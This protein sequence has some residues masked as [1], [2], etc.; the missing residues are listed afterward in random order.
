MKCLDIAEISQL[1]LLFV[2]FGA[3][4][5]LIKDEAYEKSCVHSKKLL[6]KRMKA[7]ASS[8][9]SK[10]AFC[11]AIIIQHMQ[12]FQKIKKMHLHFQII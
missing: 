11:T 12:I 9:V 5:P 10:T 3:F 8:Q 4:L 2:T 1:C 7:A 6:E